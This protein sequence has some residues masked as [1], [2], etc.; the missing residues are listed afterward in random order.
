MASSSTSE[1]D[2]E[3]LTEVM[4]PSHSKNISLARKAL[5]GKVWTTKS[6]NKAVVKEIITEA[7]N[8]YVDLHVLDMGR[9]P[10]LFFFASEAHSKEVMMKSLWYVMNHLLSLQFWLL[11]VS[12]YELDLTFCSFWIQVHK[13]PLEYLNS[14]NVSTILQKFGMVREIEDL[15]IDGRIMRTFIR[16]RVYLDITKPLP[17]GCWVPRADQP[18]I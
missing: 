17:S 12:P 3:E 10:F 7:W 9:N 1:N 5:V 6:L 18:K 15:L 16:A 4:V 14:K 13:L 11:E 8:N 2:P